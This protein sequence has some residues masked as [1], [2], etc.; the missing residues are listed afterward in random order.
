MGP[1]DLHLAS[2]GPD[3]TDAKMEST[4]LWTA[5]SS[6]MKGTCQM[7]PSAGQEDTRPLQ[8]A[9]G[10]TTLEMFQEQKGLRERR[11]VPR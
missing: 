9:L 10:K 2:Q 5:L 3:D 1:Q 6:M 4:D 8:Q 11:C 7:H